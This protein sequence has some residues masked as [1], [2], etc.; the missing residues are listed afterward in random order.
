MKQ[1]IAIA[2]CAGL[3]VACTPMDKGDKGMKMAG[4]EARAHIGHV[5][6][7]W[8]DTPDGKGLLAVAIEETEIALAHAEFAAKKPDDLK[9]MQ[10]HNHPG[11]LQHP[12]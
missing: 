11:C 5:M 9:W 10:T 8:K 12:G 6:T 4:E 7:G 1:Y 3:A 2:L